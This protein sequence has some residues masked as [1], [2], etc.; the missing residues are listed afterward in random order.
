MQVS[1]FSHEVCDR[2]R[3]RVGADF[4]FEVFLSRV[5]RQVYIYE[6]LIPSQDVVQ[7]ELDAAL[8]ESGIAHNQFY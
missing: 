2:R 1:G 6:A 5:V 4:V 3:S 7:Q 8:I